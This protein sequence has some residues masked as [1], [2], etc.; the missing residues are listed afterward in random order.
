VKLNDLESNAVSPIPDLEAQG[1]ELLTRDKNP[2]ER[3]QIYFQA[4][5]LV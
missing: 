2:E 4:V 1:K 3:G 5:E